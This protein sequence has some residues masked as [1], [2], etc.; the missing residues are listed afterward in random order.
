[1]KEKTLVFDI[2]DVINQAQHRLIAFPARHC[3]KNQ[4]LNTLCSRTGPCLS[5]QKVQIAVKGNLDQNKSDHDSEAGTWHEEMNI[6]LLVC[7]IIYLILGALVAYVDAA[8][9]RCNIFRIMFLII[10][11]APIDLWRFITRDD[12]GC[13]R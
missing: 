10:F 8:S 4:Q 9:N 2:Y 6:V 5:G 13:F 7:T 11:W 1:M 12:H 3:T